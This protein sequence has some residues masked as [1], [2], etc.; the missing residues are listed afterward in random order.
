MLHE[1]EQAI[2]NHQFVSIGLY[3]G[4]YIYGFVEEIGKSGL[5]KMHAEGVPTWIKPQE[6]MYV[7]RLVEIKNNCTG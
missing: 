6:I 7:A 1:I 5:V 2:Q 4:G 3:R